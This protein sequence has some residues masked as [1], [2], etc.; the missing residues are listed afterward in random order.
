LLDRKSM[1]GYGHLLV[2]TLQNV[3]EA[4]CIYFN[5]NEFRSQ[6]DV[7]SK[8]KYLI[9]KGKITNKNKIFIKKYQKFLKE[10]KVQSP[11][12]NLI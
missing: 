2:K 6:S 5:Y 4:K 11:K 12:L 7:Q 9:D 10:F 1:K 8:I 3:K